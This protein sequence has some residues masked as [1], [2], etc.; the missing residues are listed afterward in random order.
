VPERV[1][2]LGQ[3]DEPGF[4]SGLADVQGLHGGESLRVLLEKVGDPVQQPAPLGTAQPSPL[5]HFQSP[6]RGNDRSID[7]LR[8][9]LGDVADGL[10]GGGV[11][12]LDLVAAGYP[13][14]V[15]HGSPRKVADQVQCFSTRGCH[16]R[17]TS[18]LIDK[19][20]VG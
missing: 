2:C 9:G 4:E 11:N 6:S 14:S 16:G 20:T 18:Y 1:D 12:D 13:L 17:L 19:R 3:V 7:I 10:L 8:S 15:D 5:P